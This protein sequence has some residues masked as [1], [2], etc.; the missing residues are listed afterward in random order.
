MSALSAWGGAGKTAVARELALWMLDWAHI[1][2]DARIAQIQGK[3][4]Q[5]V[6]E[7]LGDEAYLAFEGFLAI[8]AVEES[9][10]NTIFDPGGSI[11]YHDAAIKL[12]KQESD[13]VYIRT[14]LEVIEQRVDVERRK[15]LVNLHGRSLAELYA[16]REPLYRRAAHYVIQT[17]GKDAHAVALEIKGLLFDGPN[18][19]GGGRKFIEP[20]YA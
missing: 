14:T 10:G 9:S 1:E 13:I 19:L 8:R 20:A 12:L 3:P 2:I 15:T 11:V 17:H 7:S 4:I 18:I 5:E 6:L 16:E